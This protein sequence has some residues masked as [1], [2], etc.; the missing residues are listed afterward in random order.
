ML[1]KTGQLEFMDFVISNEDVTEPKPSPEGYNLAIKR[2][3]KIKPKY[4]V[5]L[6]GKTNIKEL[7]EII[8]KSISF[9][10]SVIVFLI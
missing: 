3:K 9:L 8:S 7:I 2:L 6:C 10:N 1:E 5:N 4:I